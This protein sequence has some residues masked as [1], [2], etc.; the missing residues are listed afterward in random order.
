MNDISIRFAEV[1][2]APA[3]ALIHVTSWQKIYRGHIPDVVLDNLSV[4]QREQQWR[5]F[6]SNG[7][8][9]LVIEREN[10]ILGFASICSSRD[11]DTDS[12]MC[13]EI[14][15]IYLHPEMWHQGLG[16]QLADAALFELEKMGFSE[17]IVWV[18]DENNQ[19][20]KF[21]EALGFSVTGD[22]E[23]VTYNQ[24]VLLSEVRYRKK[25][26]KV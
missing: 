22:T 3:I 19:A 18:L 17:V 25:S 5:E 14:S 2:D 1:S 10:N 26:A 9:V 4:N 11:A 15:A 23:V 8:K 6:I 24:D 16:R 20:R 21:Y 12:N 13:G 7:V